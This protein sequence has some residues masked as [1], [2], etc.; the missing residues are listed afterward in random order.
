MSKLDDNLSPLQYQAGVLSLLDQRAP[1]T[2]AP[3]PGGP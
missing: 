1:I 3:P 2:D